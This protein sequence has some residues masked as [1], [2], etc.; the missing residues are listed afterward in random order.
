MCV[1]WSLGFK[2]ALGPCNYPFGLAALAP[3][4]APELGGVG[5]RL[6]CS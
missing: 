3:W 2:F 5:E 6:V 1:I 4:I